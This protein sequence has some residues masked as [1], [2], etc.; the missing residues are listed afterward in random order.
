MLCCDFLKKFVILSVQN[1]PLSLSSSKNSVSFNYFFIFFIILTIEF[2]LFEGFLTSV[3]NKVK[4][5]VFEKKTVG[6]IHIPIYMKSLYKSRSH[7]YE[8]KTADS[9]TRKKT[10]VI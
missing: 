2:L 10:G 6:D 3:K 4:N 9:T 5:L 1:M 7:I 8:K